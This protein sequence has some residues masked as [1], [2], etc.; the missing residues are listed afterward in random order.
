MATNTRKLSDFLAEGTGDTF[1]DLPVGKPHIKP[2]T[3]YPAYKGLLTDNTGAH[4]ITDSSAS[5]RVI[6]SV[7]DVN[8]SGLQKKIG[9]T[10]LQFGGSSDYL[11]VTDH[12]DWVVAGVQ[13]KFALVLDTDPDKENCVAESI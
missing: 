1:G 6:S 12:A 2:G 13:A 4:T 9:S 7:G 8:H 5:G 3:L 11:T 10:A